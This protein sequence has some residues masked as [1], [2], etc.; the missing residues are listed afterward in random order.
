MPSS[1]RQR[2]P[3]ETGLAGSSN[4][5]SQSIDE[6]RS[7]IASRGRTGGRAP[8]AGRLLAIRA[9]WVRASR[10]PNARAV[11]C[12]LYCPF[13]PASTADTISSVIAPTMTGAPSATSWSATGA[14]VASSAAP[15]TISTSMV[16]EIARSP[17]MRWSSR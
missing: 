4:V 15:R 14:P 11:T 13:G 6:H 12:Q 17:V 1:A 5:G 3:M 16:P 2:V 10:E 9:V 8:V 7:R